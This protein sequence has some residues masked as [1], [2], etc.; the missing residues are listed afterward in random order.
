MF[1]TPVVAQQLVKFFS[2]LVKSASDWIYVRTVPEKQRQSFYRWLI[3]WRIVQIASFLSPVLQTSVHILVSSFLSV[4]NIRN[5]LLKPRMDLNEENAP[6][7]ASVTATPAFT[8]VV[9]TNAALAWYNVNRLIEV[10]L[11]LFQQMYLS[12]TMTQQLDTKQELSTDFETLLKQAR[13]K[14]AA[15]EQEQIKNKVDTTTADGELLDALGAPVDAECRFA[16][17]GYNLQ[18]EQ[19]MKISIL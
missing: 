11:G 8:D 14:I 15:Q 19:L 16:A 3:K 7:A 17:P 5:Q 10:A 9:Y 6:T 18:L 13:E 2:P 1:L 4:N 12:M